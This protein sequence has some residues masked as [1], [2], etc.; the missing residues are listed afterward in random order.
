MKAVKVIFII[1]AFY[2]IL[3]AKL[4]S[5]Q[6]S[7]DWKQVTPAAQ[8]PTKYRHQSVVFNDKIWVLGGYSTGGF[9]NDVWSSSDG[10]NWTCATD[11]ASWSGRAD[12]GA[13]VFGNRMWVLGGYSA[14][15]R[16]NDV[17]FSFDGV[18]W[19]CIKESA[20]WSRREDLAAVVYDNRI[21]VLGGYPRLNDVW[22]SYDGL[23]WICATPAAAWSTRYQ[24]VAVDSDNKMWV[25]G[26]HDATSK[27]NDVWYTTDGINWILATSSAEWSRRE[28]HTA[29]DFMHKIW[30][31]AGDGSRLN[32]VWNARYGNDWGQATNNAAWS[33]R[34]EHTSVTFHDMIWVLGGY[35]GSRK[36]DVW[37]SRGYTMTIVSPNGGEIWSGGTTQTIR[38]RTTITDAMQYRILLSRNG[39]MTYPDTITNNLS[40]A[41]TIIQWSVPFINSNQCQLAVQA[42]EGDTLRL[43]DTSDSSFTI[44]SLMIISPNGNEIYYGGSNETI[45]WHATYPN[46]CYYRLLLTTDGLNYSDTIAGGLTPSDTFV[47]WSVPLSNSNLCRVMIQMLDSSGSVRFRDESDDFFTINTITLLSPNGREVWSGGSNKIILWQKTTSIGFSYYQ[48]LFSRNGGVTYSDTIANNIAPTESM[49]VWQLPV[50][51]IEMARV[52]IQMMNSANFVLSYDESDDNFIIDADPPSQ[53]NLLSPYNYGWAGRNVTFIWQ[54]A[55]DNFA[56]SYYQLAI[57]S[58]LDTLRAN[59]YDTVY[60]SVE[61]SAWVQATDS[62]Q[63]SARTEHSSAV[64]DNKMWVMGGEDDNDVRSDVWYSTDGLNWIQATPAADWSSRSGHSSVVFDNKLWVIGGYG[65]G[66][67]N[68]VWFSSDGVNWTCATPSAQWSPRENHTSIVY[69]SLIWVIGGIDDVGEKND[70]WCSADGINWIQVTSSA[71]WE[72]RSAHTSVVFDNKLWVLGGSYQNDVWF[73]SDGINWS[74]VTS[75]ASW[76]GRTSHT[77][78]VF[79]N[80]MWVI[81]GSSGN[82]VWYS[83]D[84][85]RWTCATYSANWSE[86][87]GHTSVVYDNKMWVIGGDFHND[88]WYSSLPMHLS[89]DIHNW[90]VTAFDRAGNNR[91]SNEI[92]SIRVDTTFPT[93]PELILPING[94]AVGESAVNFTW[95]QCTDSLSGLWSYRFRISEDPNFSTYSDSVKSDTWIIR[96]LSDTTYYWRARSIDSAGNEGNWSETRSVTVEMTSIEDR[97]LISSIYKLSLHIFPNPAKSVSII[98][99]SIPER[100]NI[101]LQLFDISGRLVK[102]LVNDNKNTGIYNLNLHTKGLSAGVYFIILKTKQKARMIERFV[103]VK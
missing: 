43:Q 6:S 66:M 89:E 53:F 3:P 90:W 20:P 94:A 82:D 5:Q 52:K 45:Q 17:W 1:I 50:A 36:N 103:I 4:Y 19:T 24:H 62:A 63:W 34:Y 47:N 41:D 29:V 33:R 92:N 70:I 99:Y 76:E 25:L 38:W 80:K 11:S 39:G 22:Y 97:N 78:V 51:N 91:I 101:L 73:S 69:N 21:W 96:T 87:E 32:D 27:K 86:R 71:Q 64:F 15:G 23:N 60:A 57:A 14:S 72:P 79:D 54:P 65:N 7:M 16:K 59:A 81:G 46:F 100:D 12:F 2:L 83:Q 31:I 37:C 88:I 68:D 40:S 75:S 26:G 44:Q 74:E 93:V 58:A 35:D 67:K 102:T 56:L 9:M 55:I 85:V 28:Q 61:G 77:S 10:E 95:H 49:L 98:R 13:V 48:L 18:N 42:Y 30:V 8:W 84:G